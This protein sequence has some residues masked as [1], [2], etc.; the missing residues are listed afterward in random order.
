MQ[1]FIVLGLIPGTNVELNFSFWITVWMGL[2]CLPIL[3]ATWR[4]R[5]LLRELIVALQVSWFIDQYQ[6][7]A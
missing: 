7:S 2:I 3:R 6:V 5:G 4:R 1:S